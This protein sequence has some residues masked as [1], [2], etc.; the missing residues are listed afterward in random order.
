[1]GNEEFDVARRPEV[2]DACAAE[3]ADQAYVGDDE[4]RYED[5]DEGGSPSRDFVGSD[6]GVVSCGCVVGI[7]KRT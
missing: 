3:M 7:G 5:E 1:V 2:A 6:A 4:A